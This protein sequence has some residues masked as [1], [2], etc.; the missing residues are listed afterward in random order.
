[1][2]D[3]S[4][5]AVTPRTLLKHRADRGSHDRAMIN[6][7]ID[8]TL[9]CHV[10][11]N[12]ETGPVVLPTCPWRMG[13]WLYVHG[14]ANSRLLERFAGATPIC[15]SMAQIDGLVLAPSALRHSLNYRSVVLFG[16]GEA[17]EEAGAKTKALLGLVDKI[18]PGRSALVR[19]PSDAELAATGVARLWIAEG[20]AKL[21]ASPPRVMADDRDWPVWAGTVPLSQCAAPPIPTDCSSGRAM[22]ALPSWLI[23]N[24]PREMANVVTST[25]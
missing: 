11:F 6:A 25:G 2:D 24:G 20:T 3:T 18:S 21:A 9:V 8:Q 15:V 12:E 14:A 17:V 19:P 13:N 1:M 23:L 7:I 5:L 4:P 16:R 22:T 10:A